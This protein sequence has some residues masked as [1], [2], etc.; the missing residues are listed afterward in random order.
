MAKKVK[1]LLDE[2]T[3][4][5]K[6]KIFCREYIFDWNGSRAYKV[7]YPNVTDETAKVNASRLLTNA[8]LKEYIKEIQLNLEELAGI[9]RL[10]VISEHMKMAFSSIAHLHNTWIERK[11]FES[12]T[13]EQKQCIEEISTKTQHKTEW[14]F[15][16]GEKV[17]V[18]YTVEYVKIKLYDKQKSLDAINKMLGYDAAVKTLITG[19]PQN[20]NITVDDSETANILKALKDEFSKIN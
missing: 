10:K 11:D 15:E 2:T 12:L 1:D 20:L 3:L 4:T 16:E 7:A 8:N 17:P 9:S 13:D 18:D 5:E 14:E 19:I 6:N